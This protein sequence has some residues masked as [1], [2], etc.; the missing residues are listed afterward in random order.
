MKEKG[1]GMQPKKMKK[2]TNQAHDLLRIENKVKG[3]ARQ[4][5]NPHKQLDNEEVVDVFGRFA[6]AV[7]VVYFDPKNEWMS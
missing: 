5:A 7:R 4:E 1:M 2:M 3:N 6:F